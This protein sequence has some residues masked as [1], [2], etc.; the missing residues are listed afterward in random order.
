M[1]PDLDIEHTLDGDQGRYW[2]ELGEGAQAEMTYLRRPDN[3]IIITHTGVP[4]AFEG[5]GI[6][7]K[8]VKRAVADAR[9]HNF[10]IVPQCPY[11]AVQFRRHPDWDELLA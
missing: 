5:R 4:P 7:L 2:A 11:V 3:A 1:T 10:K 8:L 9:E 6:A